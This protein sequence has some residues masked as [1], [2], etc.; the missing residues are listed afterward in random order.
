MEEE[1]PNKGIPRIHSRTLPL[2]SHWPELGHMAIASCKEGW[3]M[4]SFH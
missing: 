4:Q 2:T 1:G 3:E